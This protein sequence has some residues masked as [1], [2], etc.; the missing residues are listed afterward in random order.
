MTDRNGISALICHAPVCTIADDLTTNQGPKAKR[1]V[2]GDVTR[3]AELGASSAGLVGVKKRPWP[4]DHQCVPQR[5]HPAEIGHTDRTV[6]SRSICHAPMHAACGDLTTHH[7]HKV[8]ECRK[9]WSERQFFIVALGADA[10]HRQDRCFILP[11]KQLSPKHRHV[12]TLSEM[13]GGR[14][15]ESGSNRETTR[16][17]RP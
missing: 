3:C 4:I 13:E 2:G 10:K 14:R 12:P 16:A 7:G 9:S 5:P 1:H 8:E 11:L 17:V 6:S 15:S